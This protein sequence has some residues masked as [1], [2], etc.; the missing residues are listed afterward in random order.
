MQG[1]CVWV[2]DAENQQCR[3]APKTPFAQSVWSLDFSPDGALLAASGLVSGS[4]S[5]WNATTGELLFNSPKPK[6]GDVQTNAF[7]PDGT[8]LAAV[9]ETEIVVYDVATWKEVVRQP[10]EVPWLRV[11][12]FTADG[13]NLVG[14]SDAEVVVFDTETWRQPAVLTGH[15]GNPKDVDVS[16]DSRLIASSD[17]T[18]LV[19]IWDVSTGEALQ[20]IPLQQQVQNVEFIDERHLLVTPTDGPD[21]YVMTVDVDELLEIAR[22]RVT[23]DLTDEECQTYLH[24]DACPSD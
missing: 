13:R 23:R 17:S 19:R 9:N 21:A 11:I 24:V 10:L 14:I 15:R 18:G 20:G 8:L 6:D 4:I 3:K 16:P 12:V 2:F 1:W 5:V 7:S 22:S